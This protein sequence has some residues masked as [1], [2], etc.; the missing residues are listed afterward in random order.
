MTVSGLQS[1]YGNYYGTSKISSLRSTQMQ[2]LQQIMQGADRTS[3]TNRSTSVRSMA[4]AN[5]EFLKNYNKNMSNLMSSANTLRGMSS[6]S[7]WNKTTVQSSD[8]SVMQ[9]VQNYRMSTKDS[10]AVN[11]KQLATKQNNLS[12]GLQKN[13]AA[14]KDASFSI[15]TKKGTFSFQISAQDE[16]GKQK[17]NRQMMQ[18]MAD[19]VN[20][21]KIGVKATVSE[22]DDDAKISFTSEETGEKNG[23]TIEG[24]AAAAYGFDQVAQAAQDAAYTVSKNGRAE[25]S[26]TSAQNTVSMDYGRIDVTFQKAGTAT[27]QAGA[28]DTDKVVSAVK[29][30]VE[31]NNS[32]ISMLEESAEKGYGVQNQLNEMKGSSIANRYLEDIG[33]TRGTDGRLTLDEAKLTQALQEKPEQTKEL[34]SG[35]YGLAQ[36]AF[37]DARTGM[38]QSGSTLLNQ[39]SYTNLYSNYSDDYSYFSDFTNSFQML[40]LYN[41]Y[42]VQTM[43][44]VFAL[45]HFFDQYF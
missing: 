19:A 40:G 16:N 13:A 31:K 17:T 36:N 3:A 12:M 33:I 25:Q 27:I 15:T 44:N 23:F 28:V 14:E 20:E 1:L 38:A 9:A 41:R 39:N 8:K 18:E 2:K 45:G 10:Y 6:T 11:V 22:E 7:I 34:L 26:F 35:S 37:D 43:S 30:L 32:T 29:D 5:T 4:R 42:G 24:E 21:K